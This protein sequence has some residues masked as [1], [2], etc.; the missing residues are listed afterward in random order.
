MVEMV[1]SLTGLF[2]VLGFAFIAELVVP[3]GLGAIFV[4]V[5]VASRSE[6]D[7]SGRRA[8]SVFMLAT[9]FVTL[10]IAL[11]ASVA[12]VAALASLIG[13]RHAGGSGAHPVGDQVARIVV[14]SLLLGIAAGLAFAVHLPRALGATRA[15]TTATRS[16]AGPV[17]RVWQTYTAVVSFVCVMLTIAA[18][19]LA[20][21]QLFRLAGPGVFD[22]GSSSRT[23]AVRVLLP[24]AYLALAA[25][26]LMLY[27][28]RLGIVAPPSP[29]IPPSPDPAAPAA[30]EAPGPSPYGTPL[31]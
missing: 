2:G 10:F 18:V 8:V 4:I 26:G 29:P 5:V 16:P 17:A 1:G 7:P 15:E 9:A 12:T 28:Q 30:P 24:S 31:A 22:P 6:P 11:S 21:Y 14:V 27:H 25:I 19:V 23:G 13:H 3:V 20:L